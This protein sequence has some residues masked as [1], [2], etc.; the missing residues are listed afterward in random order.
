VTAKSKWVAKSTYYRRLVVFIVGIGER[1]GGR[2]GLEVIRA[3][4]K[5]FEHV[6]EMKTSF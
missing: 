1:G 4:L 5:I 3:N 2:E 6:L